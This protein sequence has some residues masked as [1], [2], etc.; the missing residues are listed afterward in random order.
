[1]IIKSAND[2]A[3]SETIYRKAGGYAHRIMRQAQQQ[4]FIAI[5]L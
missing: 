3:V 4:M 1:M 5:L 2:V